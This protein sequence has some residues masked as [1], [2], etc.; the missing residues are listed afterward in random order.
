M[1]IKRY[2]FRVVDDTA[3]VSEL[4]KIGPLHHWKHLDDGGVSIWLP[5]HCKGGITSYELK[6]NLYLSMNPNRMFQI[7]AKLD[8]CDV[9]V[10]CERD[11]LIK[12]INDVDCF[13]RNLDFVGWKYEGKKSDEVTED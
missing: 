13:I 6:V 5:R 2:G 1:M 3:D 9:V 12:T 10:K 4:E 7:S 11:V 8:H